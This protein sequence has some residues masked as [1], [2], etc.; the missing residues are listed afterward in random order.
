MEGLWLDLYHCTTS[1]VTNDISCER[2]LHE[3]TNPAEILCFRTSSPGSNYLELI[4]PLQSRARNKTSASVRMKDFQADSAYRLSSPCRFLSKN[5]TSPSSPSLIIIIAHFFCH[6]ALVDEGWLWDCLDSVRVGGPDRHLVRPANFRQRV[7]VRR[8]LCTARINEVGLH[9]VPFLVDTIVGGTVQAPILRVVA[10]VRLDSVRRDV[11]PHLKPII[12][13]I[14]RRDPQQRSARVE[15]TDEARRVALSED[16]DNLAVAVDA[17]VVLDQLQAPVDPVD[18]AVRLA[19]RHAAAHDRDLD[20]L[21]PH[22]R[23]VE[24]VDDERHAVCRHAADV[25]AV[26]AAVRDALAVLVDGLEVGLD[27]DQLVLGVLGGPAALREGSDEA[28]GGWDGEAGLQVSVWPP[29][30]HSV[31]AGVHIHDDDGGV[32]REDECLSVC[33]VTDVIAV[34]SAEV[35]DVVWG[36]HVGHGDVVWGF[37]VS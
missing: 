37:V 31:G 19:A 25:A 3:N 7:L 27:P 32:L 14:T 22:F 23:A 6:P 18:D 36:D 34:G 28:L 35:V 17:S 20:A 30:D 9:P 26:L 15:A 24:D 4:H 11:N 8:S 2:S 16:A 21:P 33:L 29:D 10:G 12:L 1:A 13:N 5:M